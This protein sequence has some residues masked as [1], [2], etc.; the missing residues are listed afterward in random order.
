MYRLHN[1]L[2]R[3]LTVAKK[4]AAPKSAKAKPMS[5]GKGG[6]KAC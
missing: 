2:L 5:K 3:S 6:K 4:K 1:H